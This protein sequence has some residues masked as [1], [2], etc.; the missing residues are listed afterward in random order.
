MAELENRKYLRWDT[1]G[2]EKIPPGEEEDINAVA[3]QINLIQKTI[4]NKTRHCF[5]GQRS[6][7]L[8][9]VILNFTSRI[10]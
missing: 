8:R 10:S 1:D 9:P 5:G 7:R 2:V 3:D 4:F 6:P